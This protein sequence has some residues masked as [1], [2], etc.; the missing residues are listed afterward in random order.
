MRGNGF[1]LGHPNGLL[2]RPELDPC[3][4]GKFRSGLG[5]PLKLRDLRASD[6][7]LLHAKGVPLPHVGFVPLRRILLGL[8][9]LAGK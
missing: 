2:F 7:I 5:L 1:L 8:C 3:R 4:L 9:R 6:L